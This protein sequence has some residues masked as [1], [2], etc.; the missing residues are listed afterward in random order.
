MSPTSNSSRWGTARTEGPLRAA[1]TASSPRG[2]RT[3]QPLALIGHPLPFRPVDRVGNSLFVSDRSRSDLISASGIGPSALHQTLIEAQATHRAAPDDH[4]SSR[5]RNS[6]VPSYR[7]SQ[8][9]AT[10]KRQ[11]SPSSGEGQSAKERNWSERKRMSNQSQG[12]PGPLSVRTR[13]GRCRTKQVLG[14]GSDPMGSS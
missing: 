14:C 3:R 4:R 12:L 7:L 6:S 10:S 8:W 9:V 5:P 11:L 2:Q 13:R 1:S